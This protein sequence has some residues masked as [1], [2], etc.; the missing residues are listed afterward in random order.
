MAIK[1]VSVTMSVLTRTSDDVMQDR[2]CRLGDREE[3]KDP[4]S[5]GLGQPA[6]AKSHRMGGNRL[7]SSRDVAGKPCYSHQAGH[8][9]ALLLHWREFSPD[10]YTPMTSQ[11]CDAI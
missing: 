2:I 9:N 3:P 5:L 6:F 4:G 1:Y 11:T 10:L 8:S 7:N